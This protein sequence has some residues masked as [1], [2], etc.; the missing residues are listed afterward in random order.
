MYQTKRFTT[1]LEAVKFIRGTL[2]ASGT[3]GA[4]S[5]TNTMTEAGKFGSAAV[6]DTLYVS[7]QT[8]YT[9]SGSGA[10]TVTISGAT[11]ASSLT[12]RLCRNKIASANI[13]FFGQSAGD[14]NSWV[15]VHDSPSFTN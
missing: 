11:N 12:W 9:I 15:V 2:V 13:I 5:G 3:A 6:G 1:L 10:N 4:I 14:S 7:G 8:A